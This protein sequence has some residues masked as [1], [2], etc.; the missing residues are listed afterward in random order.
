MKE[1]SLQVIPSIIM[2][3]I[4]EIND[5]L[6][7]YLDEFEDECMT[8]EGLKWHT[9]LTDMLCDGYDL[10]TEVM[11]AR[12]VGLNSNLIKRINK[13]YTA[14]NELT[15]DFKVWLKDTYKLTNSEIT[16]RIIERQKVDI[17]ISTN[18]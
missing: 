16:D 11:N 15:F 8:F 3:G 12:K 14:V 1:N 13:W 18:Y 5:V 4:D 6:T 2:Y 9:Y 7:A 10:S 17:Y